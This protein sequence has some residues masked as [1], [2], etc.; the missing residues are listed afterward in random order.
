MKNCLRSLSVAILLLTAMA[1]NAQT[2][3]LNFSNTAPR[4]GL[5]VEQNI[6]CQP[7]RA[8]PA[9]FQPIRGHT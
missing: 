4:E 6:A 1:L 2:R 5:S 9:G 8:Q 7:G 3:D